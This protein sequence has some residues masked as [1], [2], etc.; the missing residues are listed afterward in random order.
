[1]KGIIVA[2]KSEAEGFLQN[3]NIVSKEVK[4]GKELYKLEINGKTAVLIISG[5]GKVNAAI[6]A[7]FLLDEY[8]VDKI[9]NF[10]TSGGLSDCVKKL[11]IYLVEKCCQYDFDVSAIDDVPIGYIQD[12]K[13][14]FFNCKTEGIDF[15]DRISVATSDHITYTKD[16]IAIVKSLGC[17]AY[18]M[19][20]GAI[21]E[22]C[23][24][25]NIELISVKGISDTYESGTN[26]FYE[27][28]IKLSKMFYG[29]ISKVLDII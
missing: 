22:T 7:Q 11:N 14:V 9:I 10:G 18:D 24:A 21:A 1:M 15:L 25:N 4:L 5:I 26:D 16:H 12:Y 19:E 29:V 6:S 3:S 13:T 23:A 20:V 8:K 17:S 28:T 27:N 2:L